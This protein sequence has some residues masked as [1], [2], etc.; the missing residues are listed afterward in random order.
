MVEG[1]LYASANP[2]CYGI[3]GKDSHDISAGQPVEILLGG[4]WIP[5]RI[6]YRIRGIDSSDE[7]NPENRGAYH[8]ANYD[9]SDEVIEASKESFPASDPPEW[10]GQPEHS[11]TGS[12]VV[13]GYYFIA[14]SDNTICGLCVGMQVRTA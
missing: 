7:T 13:N 3:D 2:G 12:M 4:H 10:I 14:D 11:H 8:I 1:L 6:A 9:S 5:G